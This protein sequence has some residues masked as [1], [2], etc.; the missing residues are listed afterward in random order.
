M[1]AVSERSLLER[2]RLLDEEALAEIFD[3]YHDGIYRYALRLLGDPELAR[4]A[5]SET[6]RRYLSALQRGVGPEQFLQAY[7]Y[8]IA[9][10]WI[11]DSYRSKTPPSLPLDPLLPA[12]PDGEPP[13]QFAQA[14]ER[15]RLRN[16]LALLTPDQRQVIALKYLEQWENEQIAQALDKPVGAVKSLHHRGIQALRRVLNHDGEVSDGEA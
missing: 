7:L 13:N 9:H 6:F 1:K 14:Q 3:C 2:A 5:M 11:T 16:A 4:E 8:R 10:N 15:Q 12:D